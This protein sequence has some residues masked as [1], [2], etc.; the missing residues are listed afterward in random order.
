MKMKKNLYGQKQAGHVWNQYLHDGMIAQGFQQ[1]AVDMCV[2]YQGSVILL[3]YVDDGIYIGPSRAVIAECYQLMANDVAN[4]APINKDPSLSTLELF[5]QVQVAPMV[6]HSHT[7]GSPLHVL[8]SRF[9]KKAPKWN[10][11][12][13]IGSYLSSFSSHSQKVAPVVF[14]PQTR[15]VLPQ[16]HWS[17]ILD[18]EE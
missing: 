11:G 12:S 17:E 13:L 7:F 6:K 4:S 15:H 2:Y 9:H 3:L 5:S 16:L 1:S 10:N 14:N 18:G 8:D